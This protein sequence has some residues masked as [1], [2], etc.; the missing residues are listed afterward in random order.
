MSNL[1][2][3]YDVLHAYYSKQSSFYLALYMPLIIGTLTETS[4][5]ENFDGNIGDRICGAKD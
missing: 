4:S 5:S 2:R 1:I 3:L